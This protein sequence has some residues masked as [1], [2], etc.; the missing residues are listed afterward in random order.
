MQTTSINRMSDL[1]GAHVAHLR[2][3]A[4]PATTVRGREEL[5]RRVDRDLPFGIDSATVEEL[6]DWLA[7]HGS[8]PAAKYNYYHHIRSY[9]RWVCD[10]TN[11]RLDWD[12]SASLTRPKVPTGVPKPVTNDE[13]QQA[14][15]RAEQ[16]WYRLI[17]LAAYEGL[18]CCELATVRREDITAEDITV[19]GKGGKSRRIPTMPHVWAELRDLPRGRLVERDSYWVSWASRQHLERIGLPGVTMHRFRHWYATMQLRG[20]TDLITL[21]K[22]LGHANI[23]TTAVYCQISDEQRRTAMSTLPVLTPVST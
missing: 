1:I 20:G 16:P 17:L 3:A 4:T 2:A 13:L 7:S 22:L 8:A 15:G 9:F 19:K 6:A 11:P 18:R 12:P 23:A 5:L 21:A 10:P 14:L